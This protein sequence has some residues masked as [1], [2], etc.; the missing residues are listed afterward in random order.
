MSQASEELASLERV[1]AMSEAEW[2]QYLYLKHEEQSKALAAQ[3]QSIGRVEVQARL[4]NGRVTALERW[5][6]MMAGGLVVLSAGLPIV[7]PVI[8]GR[9]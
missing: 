3:A 4:T 8:A 6:W 9:L 2:R 7:G 5:R 1:A